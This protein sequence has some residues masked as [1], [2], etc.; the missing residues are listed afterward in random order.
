MLRG[1]IIDINSFKTGI[2]VDVIEESWIS[3]EDTRDG[4]W[5]L[6]KTEEFLYEKWNQ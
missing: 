2:I 5:D 4:K 3:F 6:S 1:K